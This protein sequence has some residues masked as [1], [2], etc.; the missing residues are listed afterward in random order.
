MRI[1]R[2]GLVLASPLVGMEVE[3]KAESADESVTACFQAIGDGDL[4]TL[5]FLLWDDYKSKDE[6]HNYC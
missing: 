1:R 3:M 4:D 2:C 5:F 6:A